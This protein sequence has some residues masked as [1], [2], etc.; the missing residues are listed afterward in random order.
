MP[1]LGEILNVLDG[2]PERHGHILVLDTNHL[3]TL[4]PALIRPGRVDRIL[5]WKKLSAASVRRFLENF[6]EKAIPATVAF[7]DRRWSAAELQGA[8]ASA[9]SYKEFTLAKNPS[10]PVRQQRSASRN[11]RAPL[12]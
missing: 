9:T 4:D 7:P 12:T 2:V 1:T 10:Q 8:A 3:A 5:S 11:R 6:Y